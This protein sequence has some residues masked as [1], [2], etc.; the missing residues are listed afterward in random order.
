MFLMTLDKETLT[1]VFLGEALLDL[2]QLLYIN[3]KQNNRLIRF[4]SYGVSHM[5]KQKRNVLIS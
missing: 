5:L 4:L 2:V 3:G 1:N